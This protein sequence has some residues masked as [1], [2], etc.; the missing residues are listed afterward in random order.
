[1]LQGNEG[2]NYKFKDFRREKIKYFVVQII[3]R[4]ICTDI[5][6]NIKML[7]HNC[8]VISRNFKILIFK[9]KV[10]S[11]IYCLDVQIDIQI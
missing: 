5:L 11:L 6:M 7:R 4:D 3:C 9:L 10:F 2:I 8:V 1:M